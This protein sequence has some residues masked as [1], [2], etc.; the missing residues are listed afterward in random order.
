MTGF[1][2]T[3]DRKSIIK[4]LR[5]T[6]NLKPQ[7]I[8]AYVQKV[9]KDWDNEYLSRIIPSVTSQDVFR[10]DDDFIDET[11]DGFIFEGIYG[12][13]C[14]KAFKED[15]K[16]KFMFGVWTGERFCF[17][18]GQ[19]RMFVESAIGTQDFHKWVASVKANFEPASKRLITEIKRVVPKYS[20]TSVTASE[21][22]AR[23]LA[24]VPEIDVQSGVAFL[25]Y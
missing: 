5:Q 13:W 7:N 19:A 1:A 21:S 15:N 2:T 10:S 20:A 22:S 6:K 12:H 8:D 23:L 14:L 11:T 16:P 17:H 9:R 18:P 24:N 4:S 25:V 3:V